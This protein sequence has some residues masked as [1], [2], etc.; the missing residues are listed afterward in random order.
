MPTLHPGLLSQTITVIIPKTT[1]FFKTMHYTPQIRKSAYSFDD[2]LKDVEK[3]FVSLSENKKK[4]LKENLDHGAALL[5]SKSQ[6]KAYLHFYG[7]IHQAKLLQA[8]ENIP[9]EIW[10]E[11]GISI[12][13][14]GCGQGI[15]E[16]V[17]SDYIASKWIDNDFIKDFTLIEPSR[18]NLLQAVEYVQAFY[19]E[20]KIR[21]YCIN[22][23]QITKE[24]IN[25][26]TN[27]II[28]IFSNVIDLEEFEGDRIAD[29]L[30]QDKSNNNIIV[31][32][33]PYYQEGTRGKRMEEFGKKLQGYS[34]R[35]KFEKHTDE[36]EKPYSCQIHIYTSRFYW[37]I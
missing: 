28:H 36:W 12:I 2:I 33:S 11:G 31:C 35:Y 16:M 22:D 13:D 7:R 34:L 27:T 15:A 1:Q 5:D 32:V 30:S 21:H 24:H 4:S 14:Y 6:L 26:N 20:S 3:W 23:K 9:K 18:E 19:F 10:S 37:L 8:F 17:L 29:I 25:T